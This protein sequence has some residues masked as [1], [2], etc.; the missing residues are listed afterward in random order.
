MKIPERA[1]EGA[2]KTVK[3]LLFGTFALIL[4]GSVIWCVI[5]WPATPHSKHVFVIDESKSVPDDARA[6]AHTAV[7]RNVSHLKRGDEIVLIPLTGDAAIE[8]PGKVQRVRISNKR[9]AYDTDLKK[10]NAN[11]RTILEKLREESAAHPYLRTDLLGS[12]SLA[13]EERRAGETFTLAI[14]S[15]M[16]N[17]TPRLNFM[18]HP[19]LA[20]DESARKLAVELMVGHQK[21]WEGARIFLGQLRS[22]D[23]KKLRSERREAI[24]AFWL[25]FFRAGG[26]T[27]VTFATDGPG[28]LADFMNPA[29][30]PKR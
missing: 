3:S 5:V 7:E 4:I 2:N 20:Q 8:A 1:F 30:Q 27:E 18:T 6:D 28:Q 11:V 13:A 14:I 16:I 26:A 19:A 23:L 22:N 29:S 10:A 15:D 21:L 12:I 24:R 17:D 25:Q 9:T